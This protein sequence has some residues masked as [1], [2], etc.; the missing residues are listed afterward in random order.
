[1]AVTYD[2]HQGGYQA[3]LCM[4]SHHD[5]EAIAVGKRCDVLEKALSTLLQMTA[6]AIPLRNTM[7]KP[8]LTVEWRDDDVLIKGLEDLK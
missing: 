7:G 8:K 1:M 5:S 3:I 2:Q 4:T 6:T